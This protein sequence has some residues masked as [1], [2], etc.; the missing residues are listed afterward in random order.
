[1]KK[2]LHLFLTEEV[3]FQNAEMIVEKIVKAN[4]KE[5]MTFMEYESEKFKAPDVEIGKI[6]LHINNMGG[7]VDGGNQIVNAILTSKIPVECRVTNAHS[8]AFVIMVACDIRKM[9]RRG[10]CMYH[11]ISSGVQGDHETI[12]ETLKQLSLDKKIADDIVVER[13]KLT[14]KDLAKI[15]RTK[16]DRYYFA[17]EALELGLISEIIEDVIK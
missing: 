8:M 6:V 5:A 11:N 7:Y 16:K 14:D 12:K 10:K 17:D 4:E 9:Y 13:T 1:M 3:T 2:D 15:F